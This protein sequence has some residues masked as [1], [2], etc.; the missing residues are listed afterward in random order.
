MSGQVISA[1]SLSEFVFR[2]KRDLDEVL[3]FSETDDSLSPESQQV[4]YAAAALRLACILEERSK[5]I[6]VLREFAGP[7]VRSRRGPSGI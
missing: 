2:L 5:S 1:E 4:C 7:V 3:V 6:P